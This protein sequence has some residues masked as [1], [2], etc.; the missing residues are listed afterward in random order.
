M[1][2]VDP[3]KPIN[4]CLNTATRA[5]SIGDAQFTS[6][7]VFAF[8]TFMSEP[9]CTAALDHNAIP[10]V[11]APVFFE[12]QP[13]PAVPTV[14]TLMDQS[15]RLPS[16]TAVGN[17]QGNTSVSSPP[18]S[19]EPEGQI[20]VGAKIGFGIAGLVLLLIIA[21][22]A[23]LWKLR[24]RKRRSQNK[25]QTEGLTVNEESPY[26][27]QKG[28]LEATANTRLELHDEERREELDGDEIHELPVTRDGL[29]EQ[30]GRRNELRGEE[31]SKE[32]E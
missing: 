10:T 12:T 13:T 17:T 4:R 23:I 31:H 20:S 14:K 32:L 15:S 8:A 22:A 7:A 24:R 27:Q 5:P 11:N 28:E 3:V 26:F 30:P 18:T 25:S 19:S 21:L 29:G 1:S 2:Y 9:E 16:S 6:E